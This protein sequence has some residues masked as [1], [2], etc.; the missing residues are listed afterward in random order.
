[1]LVG[2]ALQPLAFE[3][4]ALDAALPAASSV[5]LQLIGLLAHASGSLGM[6]GLQTRASGAG[7]AAP[8]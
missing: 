7:R 3:L 4:L 5:R 6:A 8:R 1:M 2:D